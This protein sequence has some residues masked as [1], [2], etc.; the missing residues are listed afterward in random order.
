MGV[1]GVDGVGG[2]GWLVGSGRWARVRACVPHPALVLSILR[3]HA[4]IDIHIHTHTHTRVESDPR[5]APALTS[6]PRRTDAAVIVAA[7]DD[8]YVSRESVQQL[9]QVGAGR[10]GAGGR[11]GATGGVQRWLGGRYRMH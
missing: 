8:A 4:H 9:H 5:R 1:G 11:A 2:P 7:R 3:A 6:R 10:G